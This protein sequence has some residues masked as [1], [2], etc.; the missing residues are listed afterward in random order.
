MKLPTSLDLEAASALEEM[1]EHLDRFYAL[2]GA[3]ATK[4]AVVPIAIRD[5]AIRWAKI[6]DSGSYGGDG[7]SVEDVCEELSDAVDDWVGLG[8]RA[9]IEEVN[10]IIENLP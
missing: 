1:Q 10:Q 3:D 6:P 5:A 4:M 9:T 2:L 8:P 7:P